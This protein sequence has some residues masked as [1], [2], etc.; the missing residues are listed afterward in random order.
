VRGVLC[1]GCNNILRLAKDDPNI[2]L[3]A[4]SYLA[5]T[6]HDR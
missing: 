2:L 3:S 4:V 1:N 6:T 5:V